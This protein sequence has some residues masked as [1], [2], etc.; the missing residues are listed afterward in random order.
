MTKYFTHFITFKIIIY[1]CISNPIFSPQFCP[2]YEFYTQEF[3]AI[4]PHERDRYMK[5]SFCIVIVLPDDGPVR[6]ETCT[7]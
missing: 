7:S 3:P 1:F 2:L 5:Q 4:P 6:P